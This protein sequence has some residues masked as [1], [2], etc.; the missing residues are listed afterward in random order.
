MDVLMGAHIAA[1]LLALPAGAA[2]LGAGKGGRS[3]ARAGTAFAA[4]MLAL[5]LT[6]TALDVRNGQPGA[7]LGN[8]FIGY[9][10]ATSWRAAR[11]RDGS[12]GRIDIAA[13]TLI[14]AAAAVI[15]WAAWAGAAPPTPVG[16]GPQYVLA[17]ACLLA[18]LLDLNAIL[19]ARLTAVQR[20]SRHLWRM[21]A[22]F[23]IATGSFFLGQQDVLPE[24]VRGSPVLFVLAF[25]PLAA[26]AFWLVRVRFRRPLR[27]ALDALSERPARAP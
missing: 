24:A 21:C 16:R 26:M 18:G 6:A 20:I 7:A 8:V 9:F 4:A 27:Q 2:A 11:R 15:A 23:F 17:G 25:A 5:W 13:C 10:V 19:R 3:H 1:G 22:A 12:T 14:F